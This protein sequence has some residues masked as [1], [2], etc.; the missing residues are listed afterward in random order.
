MGQSS[1]GLAKIIPVSSQRTL[2]KPSA[3]RLKRWRKIATEAAEQS[4]R[5]I[6]PKVVEPMPDYSSLVLV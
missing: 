4:E 5:L 2:L 3:N 1:W 6:L